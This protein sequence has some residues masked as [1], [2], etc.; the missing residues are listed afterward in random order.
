M[1]FSYR[2]LITMIILLKVTTFPI[3]VITESKRVH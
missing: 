1:A 3:D 2:L